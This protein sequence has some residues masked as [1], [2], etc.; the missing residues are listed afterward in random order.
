MHGVYDHRNYGETL[1]SDWFR[2]RASDYKEPTVAPSGCEPAER[3]D[4]CGKTD[5]PICGTD[6]LHLLCSNA[7]H[8]TRG[9]IALGRE[10]LRICHSGAADGVT[11]GD[12]ART[13]FLYPLHIDNAERRRAYAWAEGVLA[14]LDGDRSIEP[15]DFGGNPSEQ[16]A[17]LIGYALVQLY[18]FRERL[19]KVEA[20]QQAAHR[21]RV[22]HEQ[23]WYE[24][25]EKAEQAPA[26]ELCD[27]GAWAD[28]SPVPGQPW[29]TPDEFMPCTPAE[30]ARRLG[31]PSAAGDLSPHRRPTAQPGQR[32]ES[33]LGSDSRAQHRGYR[34][35]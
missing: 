28:E 25:R 3:G 35:R 1:M 30:K 6:E 23:R 34:G 16:A 2:D 11:V 8:D 33:G 10:I 14:A 17:F 29:I 32:A 12:L 21:L 31:I 15:G 5:C 19:A 13:R 24:R 27:S 4:S 26:A 9:V 18:R 20:Q 7:R 22:F